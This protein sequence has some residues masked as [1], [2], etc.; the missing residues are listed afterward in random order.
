MGSASGAKSGR[1]TG[2]LEVICRLVLVDD[3]GDK[4]HK[5]PQHLHGDE[6]TVLGTGKQGGEW[7]LESWN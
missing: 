3:V 7:S 2:D 6:D 1:S 5:P 4:K